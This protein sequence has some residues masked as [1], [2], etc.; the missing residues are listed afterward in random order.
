MHDLH[1]LVDD[2]LTLENVDNLLK[3]T[4]ITEVP[5]IENENLV[6]QQNPVL[7]SEVDRALVREGISQDNVLTGSRRVRFQL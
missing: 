5:P 3:Q 4:V 6:P 2:N 7:N 1:L